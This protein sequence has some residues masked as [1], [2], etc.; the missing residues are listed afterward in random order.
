MLNIDE[1]LNERQAEAVKTT[2]GPVL[3]L[4]GAG[5]GKT[6]VITYRIAHLIVNKE[7]SAG[8]ILAVTFTNKAAGEMKSRL[9]E[10]IGGLANGVWMGTF[11]S[12]CLGIL[13]NET[14]YAGLPKS[15]SIVD[16]EDRLAIIRQIIKSLN[17]D[18]KQFSPKSYLQ[19]ISSYKNTENYVKNE[20]IEETFHLLKTVYETYKRELELQ[21][22]VDFDD[23]IALCVRIFANYPDILKKYQDIYKYI[24]VD[25]YQDT[26][27]VQFRLLYMLAGI[28]GNLCVVGD[29][30]QS[31]YGWRGAEV[32]NILE[33]DKVFENVKEIKLEGNY[34]S[35]KSILSIANR[36]IEN[37]TYRRGKTLE[38]SADKQSEVK[39]Y[40]FYNDLEEASFTAK[41]ILDKHDD[42]ISYDDMA[43]LYRTNAQSLNFERAL[44]MANIP[45][46]VIGNIGFYQ[47]REV[48][49]ILAYLKFSDNP[50]DEQAFFRSISVP[51]RGIGNSTNDKIISYAEEN[52]ITILETLET[53]LK[54]LS[55][56]RAAVDRYI[57]LI[58][59]IIKCESIRDK[60]ELILNTIKYKEY[61][62]SLGEEPDIIDR[63]ME[64]IDE[65]I[66]D[67]V[68]F[69]EQNGSSLSDFLA[70]AALV[71]SNDE[72][73]IEGSVKLMTMHAAKGLEFKL[74]FL[75]GL[76]EGLFPLG[77][78]DGE[79]NI[80]EERRLCYVG[81]TRAME[82][83]YITRARSRIRGGRHNQSPES[84]FL[85]E[86]QFGRS[87]KF[88]KGSTN[89][90]FKNRSGNYADYIKNSSNY[91]KK[92]YNDDNTASFKA[93][94]KVYHSV[95]GE[96]T[97]LFSEGSGENEKV[98]V[99]F[100]K[101]GVK[102]I[103]ANFLEKA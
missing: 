49:D 29:D 9:H 76:E 92:E 50:K 96:G 14:E 93:S 91:E 100:K 59:D 79:A 1:A 85:S 43:I 34:R 55:K 102:K 15:F 38:A 74:V 4:A 11:H 47:R 27:A 57:Q 78:E 67:A 33:F 24:L 58:H 19:A 6:R 32:R 21:R 41:T 42:G 66:S 71:S 30:D 82:T 64:N 75:T 16:Q 73:D 23:M 18:P 5:T 36:L 89:N 63:K 87:F 26:N 54:F 98:T 25:E 69:E 103:I 44:K 83:L 97:V 51:K 45:H 46:K 68:R 99:H 61:L 65:L 20:P 53:D 10:L 39:K 70:S 62:Q 31:I 81:V 3:V 86:L 40:E 72:E 37:N 94:S 101:E 35:G 2:E 13:R 8:N 52:D 22:L 17:I 95:F 7:V 48:K 88:N 90:T 77:N 28:S 60:I 12:I 80:E 84:R 56:S